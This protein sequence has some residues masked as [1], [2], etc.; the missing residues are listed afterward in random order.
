MTDNKNDQQALY[1]IREISRLTG[2]KPIT[3][4]AWERRYGLVEPV[5]TTSGH[6]LYTENHL[7][8]IK[9]AMMLVATG[10]PISQVKGIITERSKLLK[11]TS[12]ANAS[13]CD[14]HDVIIQAIQAQSY[15]QLHS[16]TQRMIDAKKDYASL[17]KHLLK[18]S[19]SAN[20][21]DTNSFFWQ[22]V[23]LQ[24]L[25][26]QLYYRLHLWRKQNYQSKEMVLIVK[27]QDTP[28][29]LQKLMGLHIYEQGL[30]PVFIEQSFKNI[31]QVILPDNL[32]PFRGAI[33]LFSPLQKQ[34]EFDINL[35]VKPLGSLQ[36]WL[37][38][39]AS[40][41]NNDQAAI[42][43]ELRAWPFWFEPITLDQ[44]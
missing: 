26:Q 13:S 31:N 6:R 35:A 3:L 23:W 14:W 8:I 24:E 17:A 28:S 29:W 37:M 21:L 11:D 12:P 34:E 43:S 22:Q 39:C 36:S 16:L 33:Y 42:A 41:E 1:P 4:R 32:T 27:H 25:S 15:Q 38:G 44:N 10:L 9:E 5:R 2:I 19:Q 40:F 30:T 20:E 18:L 7:A